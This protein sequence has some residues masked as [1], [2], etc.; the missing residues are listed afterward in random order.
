MLLFMYKVVF[1][2]GKTVE[3]TDE[4]HRRIQDAIARSMTSRR[5]REWLAH[6]KEMVYLR[7]SHTSLQRHRIH[8]TKD[9][10]DSRCSGCQKDAA[11][12]QKRYEELHGHGL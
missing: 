7:D 4:K 3:I 5:Q 9:M 11:A 12:R 6:V 1:T 8:E 10:F 2:N